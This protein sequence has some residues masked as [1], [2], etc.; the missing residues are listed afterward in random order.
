MGAAIDVASQI[1]L[2][3]RTTYHRKCR[4][5][6]FEAMS[7]FAASPHEVR[8]LL[9]LHQFRRLCSVH[10]IRQVQRHWQRREILRVGG[11]G[12]IGLSLPQILAAETSSNESSN[13][14]ADA[15]IVIFLNG[16]P[17]HLDMWDMKP[18]AQSDIRGEFAPI[19]SSLAGVQVCEHLPRLA[20]HMHRVSLDRK[21]VV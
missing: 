20:R 14:R 21:S 11:L 18:N 15:C 12:A 5:H 16:G 4:P 9:K 3:R 19:A 1:D 2:W 7:T 8:R 6:D 13:R 10:K 17:S